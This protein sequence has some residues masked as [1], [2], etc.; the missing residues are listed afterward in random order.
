M[1]RLDLRQLVIGDKYILHNDS[2]KDIIATVLNTGW[3]LLSTDFVLIMTL[4]VADASV[5]QINAFDMI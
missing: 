5:N 3:L 2:L 1:L 4:C